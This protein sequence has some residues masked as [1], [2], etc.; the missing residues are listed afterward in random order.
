MCWKPWSRARKGVVGAIALPIFLATGSQFLGV[1]W[2]SA[3]IPAAMT[4]IEQWLEPLRSTNHYGLFAVMTVNRPEIIV[5]GSD[6]GITWKPYRFRW[7]PQELDDRPRFTTPHLPR[8]DWQMWFA[9]LSGECR[10]QPWFLRF[11]QCLLAGSPQVLALLEFN[12]FSDRPPRQIRASL[13]QYDFTRRGSSEWWVRKN[14]G[15]FCPPVTRQAFERPGG[16]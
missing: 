16:D 12:P 11:E 13:F 2:P 14:A 3:P 6:D 8:L 10:T 7:K 9:A 1:V 4:L 15:L 5:E